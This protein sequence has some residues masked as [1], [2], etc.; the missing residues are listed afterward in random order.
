MS[1]LQPKTAPPALPAP[2]P[3]GMT[4]YDKMYPAPQFGHPHHKYSP[5]HP[6]RPNK[7]LRDRFDRINRLVRNDADR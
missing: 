5:C 7:M 4:P 2:R 3:I 1:F 6:H